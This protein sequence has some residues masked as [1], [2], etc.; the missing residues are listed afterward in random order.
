M[1]A[2]D[3][4]FVAPWSLGATRI[5]KRPLLPRARR[6]ELS[7]LSSEQALHALSLL[8]ILRRQSNRFTYHTG[9]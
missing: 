7:F 3:A 9:G 5:A 1:A 6:T 8:W 4:E 2:I